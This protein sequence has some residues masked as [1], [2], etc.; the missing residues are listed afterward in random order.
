MNKKI[1]LIFPLFW[2]AAVFFALIFAVSFAAV[3][4]S[5]H[6]ELVPDAETK[7]RLRIDSLNQNTAVMVNSL[8]TSTKNTALFFVNMFDKYTTDMD[9]NTFTYTFYKAHPKTAGIIIHKKNTP[10]NTAQKIFNI[11]LLNTH[12]LDYSSFYDYLNVHETELAGAAE[13][14]GGV[15]SA[16]NEFNYPVMIFALPESLDA[17]YYCFFLADDIVSA[18]ETANDT[19]SGKALLVNTKG[20]ILAAS[21]GVYPIN[22]TFLRNIRAAIDSAILSPNAAAGSYIFSENGHG[23][24]FAV[25]RK[26]AQD[27]IL[28]HYRNLSASAYDEKFLILRGIFLALAFFLLALFALRLLSKTA[29]VPLNALDGAAREAAAG[30]FDTK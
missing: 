14:G 5:I 6:R 13:N 19:E 11:D 29:L 24:Q 2:K 25:L 10:V 23:K 27:T 9:K 4:F 26:T 17:R 21:S 7:A 20:E 1:K 12:I 16:Q 30:N 3:L 8:L 22:S 15:F 18:F 28:I